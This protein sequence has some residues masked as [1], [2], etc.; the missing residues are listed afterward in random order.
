[1][2][3]WSVATGERRRLTSSPP[4][5]GIDTGPALSPDG[6][7]LAFTRFVSYEFGDLFVLPLTGDLRPAGEPKRLTY[8]NRFSA[9]PA[10]TPDGREIIFSS[11]PTAGATSLFAVDASSFERG[12]SKPRRLT[13]IGEQAGGPSIARPSGSGRSHMVYTQSHS[14]PDIWRIQLPDTDGKANTAEPSRVPFIYSTQSEYMPQYSPDGRRVA[15]VS[16]I[17]G[18]GEIWVC[19]KDGAKPV[20]LTTA[21]W[22]ITI[23]PSWSPDS[24]QIAFQAAR[25]G[26]GDIFTIPAGGGAP[27][28]L[29]DDL[30]N[31]WGPSWSRDS[32]WIYFVS[33]R[34]GRDQVWKV[35]AGGGKFV[36]VTMN[37]GWRIPTEGGDERQ[38]LESLRDWNEFALTEQGIYFIPSSETPRESTIEFFSFSNEK[39]HTVAR[40]EKG[41]PA[42]ETSG[43]GRRGLTVSPD[44]RELLYVQSDQPGTDLMLVENFR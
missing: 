33:N 21:G 32:R 9:F 20:Q 2:F 4:T 39:I 37:G 10:W 22:P 19:D 38:V 6:R 7:R 43:L 44:G 42:G 28:R 3:A 1:L 14:N 23:S 18:V 26:A 29:T 35:P 17:S 5:A 25:D 36:Q 41:F 15:F 31:D 24:S 34:S 40:L 13:S 12:T 27:K 16:H 8:E 11:G 30:G